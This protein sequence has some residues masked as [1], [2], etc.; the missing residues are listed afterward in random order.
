MLKAASV[1]L[2]LARTICSG[3]YLAVVAGD[4]ASVQ[5]SVEAGRTRCTT[6]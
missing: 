3:K 5:A 4:V 6:V 2:L 1:E